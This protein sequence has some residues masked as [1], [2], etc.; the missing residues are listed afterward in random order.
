MTN[1]LWDKFKEKLLEAL[2]HLIVFGGAGLIGW[3]IIVAYAGDA[4]IEQKF[5]DH[6]NKTVQREAAIVQDVAETKKIALDTQK[7]IKELC[8]SLKGD[9]TTNLPGPPIPLVKPPRLVPDPDINP[10]QHSLDFIKE[11]QEAYTK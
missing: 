4:K 1:P 11:N 5:I 7:A 10:A 9:R 6:H 8:E 3:A 2:A